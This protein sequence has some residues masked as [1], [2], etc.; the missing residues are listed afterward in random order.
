[1]ITNGTLHEIA[2]RARAL[3]NAGQVYGR[4]WSLAQICDHLA[5]SID[6]TVKG[7]AVHGTS[8]RSRRLTRCGRMKRWGFKRYMLW[9]GWFPA[10][11]PAPESVRPADDVPLEEALAKLRAAAGAFERTCAQADP[12]WSEHS[13]LGRFSARGWR[14]FHHI[15]AA[16]HFSFLRG[17][18][19]TAVP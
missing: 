4:G 14:R 18:P 9:T 3:A 6:N 16:H 17:E 5:R 13:Y 8:L 15:H 7:S 11:V 10:G 2:E 12:S 1:M 19:G